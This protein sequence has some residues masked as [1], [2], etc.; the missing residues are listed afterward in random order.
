MKFITEIKHPRGLPTAK[1]KLKAEFLGINS[2][3]DAPC[4]KRAAASSTIQKLLAP[5]LPSGPWSG[6]VRP[7]SGSHY[8]Q[9]TAPVKW[10][11]LTLLAAEPHGSYYNLHHCQTPCLLTPR[12]LVGG[13]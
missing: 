11:F 13:Q 4:S 5:S 8:G 2:Q 10:L 3:N 12:N 7:W 6:Q 1:D 9:E